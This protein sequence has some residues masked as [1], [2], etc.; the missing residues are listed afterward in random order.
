MVGIIRD[1]TER[2]RAEEAIK[3]YAHELEESNHI[4]DLFTDIMHHDL[5]N[6]LATAKG[7]IELIKE[8]EASPDKAKC[9]E[10]IERSLEKSME[11]IDSATKFSKIESLESIEFEDMDLSDLIRE[12]VENFD[13]EAAKKRA[14]IENNICQS[15]QIRANKIIEEVFVNLISNAIKYAPEGRIT[16]EGED[17]GVFYRVRVIDSGEGIKDEDKDMIFE[18]FRRKE[19][20]GVKGTGLGLAIARKV[21]ELHKGRIWVEDNP[22]GGA[23]F[24]VDIP[25]HLE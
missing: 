18:R 16:L 25:K 5:L 8:T 9:V 1:I 14:T 7:F 17:G 2:K 12:V 15:M 19:K 23:V 22:E 6:P 20:K 3:R 21:V 24:V 13:Q 4:K 10:I 11:L